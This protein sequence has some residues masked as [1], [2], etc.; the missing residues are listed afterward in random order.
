MSKPAH[1]PI[2]IYE[3]TQ[4]HQ[5]R[6]FVLYAETIR[7]TGSTLSGDGDQTISLNQL[8]PIFARSWVYSYYFAVGVWV[9]LLAICAFL[10][11]SI[12]T[13]IQDART[14]PARL[15]GMTGS[16]AAVGLVLVFANRRKIEFAVFRS[17]AGVPI[18]TVARAGRSASEF[19]SFVALLVERIA[20]ARGGTV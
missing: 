19:D 9:F 2:A 5:K 8:D 20:L 13:E 6:R 7:V 14:L 17:D 18:L 3:E 1:V 10:A 12:V 15:M 16:I 11:I 4:P